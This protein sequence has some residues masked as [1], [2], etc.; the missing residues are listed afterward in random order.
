[1]NAVGTRTGVTAAVLSFLLLVA[2]SGAVPGDPALLTGL[3]GLVIV[4]CATVR[5]AG[6][7]S[8]PAVLVRA[9]RRA[10]EQHAPPRQHDP[11]AAGHIRSRAPAGPLPAV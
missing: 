11:A 6:P 8:G 7:S 9:L 10:Q 5:L 3:V 2:A 4:V 1:M